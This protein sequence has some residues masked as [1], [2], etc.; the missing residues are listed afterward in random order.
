MGSL[1]C[2][3][4]EEKPHIAA[5]LLSAAPAGIPSDVP[6]VVGFNWYS[7][8]DSPVEIGGSYH[9]PDVAKGANLGT[10]RGGHCFCFEPM[11]AVRRNRGVAQVFY[12]Q[13]D[14]GAC[15]GFGNSRAISI[16]RGE[17]EL[18]DAFWLYD[19]ARRLEGT[20]P[21]GEGSTV[22]AGAQVLLS[23]GHRVQTGEKVCARETGDQP[24]ALLDGI[25]AIRWAT[26]TDEVLAALARPNALAIPFENSWGL[27]YP[28]VVWMPVATFD[29]LLSESGEA[30]V[31]T[32]R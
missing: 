27:E 26:S 7:S 1:G 17:Q 16:H 6:V 21:E 28:Q 31:Y 3:I 18:F 12:N 14:E 23:K 15:V 25:S 13:G 20:Y 10:V 32:E 8:F 4:P 2:L 24:P 9:L 30:G 5:S 29:R 19:E 22:H 11:G